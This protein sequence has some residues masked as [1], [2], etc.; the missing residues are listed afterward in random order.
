MLERFAADGAEWK[1]VGVA[2][3]VAS[4]IFYGLFL[5]Y[6]ATNHDGF[7]FID[8]ANLVVHEGGHALFGWFGY[9][10]GIM[11]GTLLQWLV[12]F[13]L[14][15]YFFYHRQV[16]GF[17]FCTFFFFEN[18]LYTATY[19]ADARAEAL[20]LVSLGGGD[21]VEHDWNTMFGWWGLLNRDTQIAGVVRL[22]GWVGMI[23]VVM[24][25]GV[26]YWCD[27]KTERM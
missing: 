3:V 6:A 5:I 7:L 23:G 2:G 8:N 9:K 19:M 18:F 22:L 10:I 21:Y 12:P 15:A 25:L 26:R 1:P 16:W 17:V 4:A 20:P 14:A 11:G 24:W 13:L 27:R